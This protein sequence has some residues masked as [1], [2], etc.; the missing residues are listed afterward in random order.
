M[1]R[2]M[3]RREAWK[4]QP[5]EASRFVA[6]AGGS[7]GCSAASREPPPNDSESRGRAVAT[8]A[9]KTSSL[10][11]LIRDYLVTCKA[12]CEVI[13]PWMDREFTVILRCFHG[14]FTV[15]LR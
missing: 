15:F 8:R 2:M 9:L 11:P 3:N 5:R 10:Q 14:E 1:N 12:L 4:A 13:S 6:Q 7:A